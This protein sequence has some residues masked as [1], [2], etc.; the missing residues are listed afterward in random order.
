MVVEA[1]DSDPWGYNPIFKGDEQVGMTSSGGYGH[2]VGKSIAFG[3]VK[4]ELAKIRSILKSLTLARHT[5]FHFSL[6]KRH[7]K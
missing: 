7:V 5:C 3:Y 1:E 4:P 2:R 6:D